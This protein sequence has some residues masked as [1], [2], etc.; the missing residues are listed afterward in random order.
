[1]VWKKRGDG[2]IALKIARTLLLVHAYEACVAGAVIPAKPANGEIDGA[3]LKE[4]QAL[5][6]A[7]EASDP[8]IAAEEP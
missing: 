6:A 2:N 1:M 8:Q 5:I 4:A 7:L 3:K